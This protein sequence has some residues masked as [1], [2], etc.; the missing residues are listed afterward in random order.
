MCRIPPVKVS[1]SHQKG[2]AFLGML[3]LFDR[4][5]P[6]GR[7]TSSL[8]LENAVTMGAAGKSALGRDDV[9]AVIGIFP[10]HLLGCTEADLAEPYPE[11]GMLALVEK[12]AQLILRDAERTGKREHIR[13]AVLVSLILTPGIQALLYE[14]PAFIRNNLQMPGVI[15][16]RILLSV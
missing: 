4:F 6:F 3:L 8:S 10:H 15:I 9:V 11:V 12:Q 1:H 13:I 14:V 5:S 16:C 7:R 2:V